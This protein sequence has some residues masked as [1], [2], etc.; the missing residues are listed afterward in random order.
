MESQWLEVRTEQQGACIIRY[1]HK[2]SNQKF[3]IRITEEQTEEPE[4]VHA[5]LARVDQD[6]L[7][8]GDRFTLLIKSV[9]RYNKAQNTRHPSFETALEYIENR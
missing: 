4:S 9:E 3:I 5:Y 2:N 1:K 7:A 6:E 8:H